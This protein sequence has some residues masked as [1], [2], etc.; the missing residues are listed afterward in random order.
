MNCVTTVV[1]LRRLCWCLCRGYFFL[2]YCGGYTIVRLRH[3]CRQYIFL[4]RHS[5]SATSVVALGRQLYW[6][7]R[8]GRHHSSDAVRKNINWFIFRLP[9]LKIVNCVTTVVYLRRLCWCLCRGYFF[10]NHCGGYTIVELRHFRRRYIFLSQR[11]GNAV[12]N[13]LKNMF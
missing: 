11:G 9:V 13:I 5:G 4:N 6:R 7:Q 10:L 1:Y 12:R 2:N 3:L 8:S